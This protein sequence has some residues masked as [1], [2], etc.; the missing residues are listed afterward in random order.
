MI[1]EYADHGDLYR[2]LRYKGPLPESIVVTEVLG[3]LMEA[4]GYMH[5]LGLVHRDLKPENILITAD[6]IK[7]ADLGLVINDI[8]EKPNT[9]LGTLDYMVRSLRSWLTDLV[10]NIT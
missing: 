7:V 1:L 8:Q 10:S 3:P 9:R 2:I 4:L 6:G 5:E